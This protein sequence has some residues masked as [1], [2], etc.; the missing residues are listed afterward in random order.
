MTAE[1]T[2][3]SSPGG[4]LLGG[5]SPWGRGSEARHPAS[6]CGQEPLS[7]RGEEDREIT[8]GTAGRII[9]IFWFHFLYQSHPKQYC[10]T[11]TL[12]YIV[13]EWHGFMSALPHTYITTTT[14]TVIGLQELWHEEEG[15]SPQVHGVL[16]HEE[17]VE[18]AHQ[19]PYQ[20]IHPPRQGHHMDHEWVNI[21][22][23]DR[24]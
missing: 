14:T 10:N 9:F 20:L 13:F 1:Q 16:E 15:A 19:V 24:T 22:N 6:S 18:V 5:H 17:E 8:R 21:T 12:G 3:S 11:V 23:I 2:S 4:G 7:E